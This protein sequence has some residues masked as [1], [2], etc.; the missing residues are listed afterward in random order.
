MDRQRGSGGKRAGRGSPILERAQDAFE[1]GAESAAALRKFRLV[2]GLF[3][4]AL[5]ASGVTAF[6]LERELQVL[7]LLGGLEQAPPA[8]GW[9]GLDAW[10][11]T[12]RNGLR[13]VYQ[14]YPWMAYGTDWLA[15][16][17][18]AIAVFFLGP[19]ISPVRNIW[20]LQAGLIVCGLVVPLALV[21]GAVRQIP[22][23]WRLID[24]SFGIFGAIPLYYCLRLARTLEKS[25]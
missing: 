11:L 23:G 17:H 3:I 1:F 19:L 22:L 12:V 14:Q 16:A 2:L 21:C 7:V 6:P 4:A 24:C 5:V 25:D 10:I 13:D 9:T 18:I 15:F 20:V 8:G